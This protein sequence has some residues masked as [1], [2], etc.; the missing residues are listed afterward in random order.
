MPVKTARI[1]SPGIKI[2]ESPTA[3]FN[4]SFESAYEGKGKKTA[5]EPPR[6]EK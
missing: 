1:I 5:I 3:G 2:G 6:R 4:K